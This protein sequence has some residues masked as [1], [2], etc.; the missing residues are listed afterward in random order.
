MGGDQNSRRSCYSTCGVIIY[1][2]FSP[3]FFM[4]LDAKLLLRFLFIAFL[5][6]PSL[7]GRHVLTRRR[8]GEEKTR[9]SNSS[10]G[11]TVEAIKWTTNYIQDVATAT[12]DHQVDKYGELLQVHSEDGYERRCGRKFGNPQQLCPS[13]V[14]QNHREKGRATTASECGGACVRHKRC[15]SWS[16]SGGNGN[17]SISSTAGSSCELYARVLRRYQPSATSS[18]SSSSSRLPRHAS[19]VSRARRRNGSG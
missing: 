14:I 9:K 7:S 17:S 1:L 5:L 16:L 2:M 4:A 10:N 18:S 11:S 6:T 12:M 3:H 13:A 8:R 15:R 19:S